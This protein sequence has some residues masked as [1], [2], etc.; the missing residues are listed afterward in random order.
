VKNLSPPKPSP[1]PPP[2]Q[3]PV[4]DVPEPRPSDIVNPAVAPRAAGTCDLDRGQRGHLVEGHE[5]AAL[6]AGSLPRWYPGR[7]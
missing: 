7:S 5:S 3:A 1:V 4:V 2:P 6:P